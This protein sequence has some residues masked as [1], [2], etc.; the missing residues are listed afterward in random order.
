[1]RKQKALKKILMRAL[2]LSVLSRY[3]FVHTLELAKEAFFICKFKTRAAKAGK[4][5]KALTW[6][7]QQRKSAS[8]RVECM[9]LI[10]S[11]GF[12]APMKMLI[13]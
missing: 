6:F 1:M 11:F 3:L 2:Q 10:V 7:H 4:K 12:T 5:T 9:P 13:Y 8:I